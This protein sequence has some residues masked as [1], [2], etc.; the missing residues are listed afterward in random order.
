MHNV[1]GG[2]D[3]AGAGLSGGGINAQGVL[4]QIQPP[5]GNGAQIHGQA[6]KQQQVIRWQILNLPIQ[7]GDGDGAQM[8]VV[9]V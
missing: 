6:K 8:S 5:R 7:M 1:T 2:E 3:P 9:P 4:D